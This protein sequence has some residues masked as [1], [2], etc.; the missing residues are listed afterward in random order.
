MNPT[1]A[2]PG[3]ADM[4]RHVAGKAVSLLYETND[5]FWFER[6]LYYPV[7][8]VRPAIDVDIDMDAGEKTI[9]W[10]KTSGE[11][12]M[13]NA[14]E[15]RTAGK[16]RHYF[17]SVAYKGDLIGYAKVAT[18]RVYIHDYRREIALP[19]RTAF[20]YDTYVSPRFRGRKV[21]RYLI[22]K[23][24]L[25]LRGDGFDVVGCHIPPWN[26]SSINAYTGAGFKC[27]RYARYR[28]IAAIGW[29]EERKL[30]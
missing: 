14:N 24:M 11:R 5:A 23:I 22:S 25:R 1:F 15:S 4:L 20:I 12:W 2:N 16:A 28:R 26:S 13:F 10:I 30:Q 3:V 6:N 27:V 19:E 9:S 29:I 21:A 17:P 18:Q 7:A 8:A